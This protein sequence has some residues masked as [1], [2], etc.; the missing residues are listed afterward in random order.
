VRVLFAV[1]IVALLAG[2]S[3]SAPAGPTDPL[4][5]TWTDSHGVVHG[6]VAVSGPGEAWSATDSPIWVVRSSECLHC[7]ATSGTL[8]SLH[9]DGSVLVAD[10]AATS[11]A[12][13]TFAG[14]ADAGLSLPFRLAFQ[15]VHGHAPD[16]IRVGAVHAKRLG[17]TDLALV[18][19]ELRAGLAVATDPGGAD[20]SA[21]TSCQDVRYAAVS[22]PHAWTIQAGPG[23]TGDRGWAVVAGEVD[24][25]QL[26]AGS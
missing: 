25:L 9:R 7:N 18:T 11:A 20:L 5:A 4:D 12:G 24:A 19:D 26:W 1:T 23:L 3:G 8:M 21:C 2:C 15:Q 22:P 17:T 13:V 6:G 16:H 10:Y 14:S